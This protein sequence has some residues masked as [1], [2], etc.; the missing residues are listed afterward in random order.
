[1][2]GLVDGLMQAPGATFV[3]RLQE[4]QAVESGEAHGRKH[5]GGHLH[6]L[7]RVAL[8]PLLIEVAAALNCHGDRFAQRQVQHGLAPLVHGGRRKR[9]AAR[10]R[11]S[12]GLQREEGD[13]NI[14][15]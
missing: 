11:K 10:G 2:A 4:I 6:G 1:M 12:F 5:Q 13:D 3:V 14:V 15:P 9:Q 7:A 8:L